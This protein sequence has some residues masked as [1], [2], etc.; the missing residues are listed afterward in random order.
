MIPLRQAHTGGAYL[1]TLS[2]ELIIIIGRGK[3]PV[4]RVAATKQVMKFVRGLGF[5]IIALSPQR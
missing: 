5:V 3:S 1:M 2:Y 4:G